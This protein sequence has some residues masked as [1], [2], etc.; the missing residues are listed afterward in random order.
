MKPR[1]WPLRSVC[2]ALLFAAPFAV[3]FA[4]DGQR[5]PIG[6]FT[7][8][9]F[10]KPPV[11]DGV[12]SPGEW[13]RALTTSG[14]LA[15]FEHELQET[16]T[17]VSLGFDAQN[18]YFLVQCRRGNFE[19]KL[20]KFCRQNDDYNFGEP[21][22]EIWVTPPAQVPETYQS[23]INTYPAV[24][25]CKMI[26]TRGYTGM[27]WKGNWKIGV[28]ETDTDFV[29]EASVPIKDF[30]PETIKNGDI[31]RFL[32]CRTCQGAKPRAQASWSITQ[33]FAE[34]PS[35]P[36]VHLLDDSPVL[37]LTG[38][39]TIFT[40]KY[41]FPVGVVAPR[42]TGAEVD[43]ELRFQKAKTAGAGDRIEK[44]HVS[45]KAG[46]R[47]VVTFAGDVTDWTPAGGDGVKRANFTVTGTKADGGLIFRQSFAYVISGWTPQT[48]VKPANEPAVQELA[49]NA[50]YGPETNTLLVKADIFDLPTRAKA[51]TASG[52]SSR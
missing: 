19:W 16:V 43:V 30:G 10:E 41:D 9:R 23:I 38:V 40:G 15:P 12:A 52:A 25:D 39:Q 5:L 36:Q 8:T 44:Q 7:A 33:G 27:G 34:I 26:P 48:P 20:W 28:K 46:E 21:S 37:Q 50:Q 18:L 45:L 42:Q 32:L 24:F 35:H 22:I 2:T 29:I 47:K 51:A 13:D 4:Q 17:V 31:W 14:M 1:S 6:E 49:I 3:T 11:I